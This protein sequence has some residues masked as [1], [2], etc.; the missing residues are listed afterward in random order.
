MDIKAVLKKLADSSDAESNARAYRELLEKSE[1][2][3]SDDL[4]AFVESENKLLEGKAPEG[5]ALSPI[6]E[7]SDARTAVNHFIPDESGDAWELAKKR[8]LL[9]YAD[10]LKRL[11]FEPDRDKWNARYEADND[12]VVIQAKFLVKGFIEKTQIFLHEF[13]HRGQVKDPKSYEAFLGLG[14]NKLENFLDMANK[15]HREDY[16]KNDV[17]STE[18]SEEAFAEGY[19]RFCLGL[20]MPDELRA[21][22]QERAKR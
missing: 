5:K 16:A 6:E 11:T 7:A 17:D 18:V 19:S 8:D 4:Q 20:E 1:A 13:G 22:W 14:L 12:V 2:A 9:G 3:D 15:V 21:F 10:G